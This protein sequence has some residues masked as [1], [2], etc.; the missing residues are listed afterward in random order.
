VEN[1]KLVGDLN[2]PAN[3]LAVLSRLTQTGE[4]KNATDLMECGPSS[5]IGG[6]LLAGGTDGLMDIMDATLSHCDPKHK[7][8]LGEEMAE[9]QKAMKEGKL[10]FGH[11]QALQKNLYTVMQ[12]DMEGENPDVIKEYLD[13]KKNSGEG[14]DATKAKE[15]AAAKTGGIYTDT[16]TQFLATSPELRKR[17]KDNGLS[18]AHID[19]DGVLDGYGRNDAEHFVLHMKNMEGKDQAFYDPWQRKHGQLVTQAEE[20]KQYS[21]ARIRTVDG[22]PKPS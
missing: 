22:E 14:S 7:E 17:F 8:K 13:E 5:L 15:E 16:I 2:N 3:R 20:V 21:D 12:R 4:D 18:I 1:K 19:N 10:N 9:I 6:A 11:L